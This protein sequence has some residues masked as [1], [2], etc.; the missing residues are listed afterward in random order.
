MQSFYK[1]VNDY[2]D[3]KKR[4]QEI[5][6]TE[7]TTSVRKVWTDVPFSMRTMVTNFVQFLKSINYNNLQSAVNVVKDEGRKSGNT[8]VVSIL[9][10]VEFFIN[11]IRNLMSVLSFGLSDRL[12]EIFQNILLNN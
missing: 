2:V 4:N 5:N 11:R 7:L 6:N 8:F 9:E 12:F 1:L 3:R 10:T